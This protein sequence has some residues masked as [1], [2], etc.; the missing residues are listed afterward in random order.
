MPRFIHSF[1]STKVKKY[2]HFFFIRNQ[3]KALIVAAFIRKKKVHLRNEA[4]LDSHFRM[5]SENF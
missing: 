5:L 4:R 3:D 2:S 1:K